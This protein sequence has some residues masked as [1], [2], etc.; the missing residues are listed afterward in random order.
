SGRSIRHPDPDPLRRHGAGL[1]DRY[2]Q[3]RAL[4]L[5]GTGFGTAMM[6]N[7]EYRDCILKATNVSLTLGKTVILRDLNAEIRDVYRPGLVTGQVVGVL[8]PS[9]IGKT[10]LF[11][12]LSGIDQPDTGSVLIGDR[13][14]KRG[15]VGVVAQNYPL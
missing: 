6:A 3:T 8:G 2:Y 5:R 4:P 1:R 11:R 7:C 12:I 14:V 13:P 9:G 15:M 10:R